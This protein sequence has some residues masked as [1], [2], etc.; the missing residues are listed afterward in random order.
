ML[1]LLEQDLDYLCF[2]II[3]TGSL[4]QMPASSFP[5]IDRLSGT[6]ISA[7]H[8]KKLLRTSKSEISK[9]AFVA[10]Q[11]SESEKND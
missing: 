2:L 9:Q 6:Q 3:Q 5:A 10:K 4:P 8:C 1:R 7:F 11:E